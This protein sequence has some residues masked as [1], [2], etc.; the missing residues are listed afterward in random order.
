MIHHLV[1]WLA[2]RGVAKIPG[3]IRDGLSGPSREQRDEAEK[4][5]AAMRQMMAQ[6]AQE[7]SLRKARLAE[8]R[9][10]GLILPPEQAAALYHK[11]MDYWHGTFL[12]RQDRRKAAE[13]IR[14]A[15]RNGDENAR[16][17]AKM[18]GWNFCSRTRLRRTSSVGGSLRLS[19][20][21]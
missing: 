15:A 14:Q 13:F 17:M 6:A 11:G 9:R 18:N 1:A 3:A 20:R 10:K 8:D 4:H 2:L 21:P 19:S 16:M 7:R 5:A 12:I